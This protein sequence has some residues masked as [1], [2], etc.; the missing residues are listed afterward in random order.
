MLSTS[1]QRGILA[2]AILLASSSA[3]SSAISRQISYDYIQGTYT[4]ITDSSLLNGDIDG[5]GLGVSGAFSITRNVAI[6]VGYE[7]TSYDRYQGIDIDT[8][9]F[10]LGIAVHT[11]IAARTDIVGNISALKA[12]SEATDGITTVDENDTGVILG[13]AL[14]HLVTNSIELDAGISYTDVY[15]DQS[16]T[17]GLGARFYASEAISLGIGYATS[18]DIDALLFNVR[19]DI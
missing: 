19:F 15:D 2:V 9:G 5:D 18:D 7:A 14:R 1:V 17:F 16:T 8:S 13:I 12:K 11:P 6:T 3:S 10:T 4:S